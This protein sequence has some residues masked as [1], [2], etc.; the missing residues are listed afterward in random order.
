MF[1]AARAETCQSRRM[2]STANQL[3]KLSFR[4]NPRISTEEFRI[5]GRLTS[6]S[7]NWQILV[8]LLQLTQFQFETVVPYLG[9]IAFVVFEL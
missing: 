4:A 1:Q 3:T 7:F 8:N 5:G 2:I 6:Y 9:S